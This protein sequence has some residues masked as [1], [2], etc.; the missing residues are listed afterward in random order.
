MRKSA[1][2]FVVFLL[3]GCL[4]LVSCLAGPQPDGTETPGAGEGAG[5]STGQGQPNP[6]PAPVPPPAA[7]KPEDNIP[8]EPDE[9]LLAEIAAKREIVLEQGRL[10]Y[11]GYFYEEAIALLNEDEAL[12]NEETEELEEEIKQAVDDM[13]LF[14]GNI[15]HIFF[16]S[17]ILYPQHLFPNINV[18][19]GGYNEGFAYQSELIRMLRSFLIEA[20]SFTTSTTYS[21]KTKT[22]S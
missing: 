18:P 13:E 9:Q 14:E 2:I 8:D 10:L 17:L 7:P 20:M 5:D 16:H 11:K 15:K 6:G 19:T 1:I 21:E 12:I 3:I 22:A 4:W